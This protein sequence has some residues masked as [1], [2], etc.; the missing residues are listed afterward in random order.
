MTFKLGSSKGLQAQGGNINSTMK[1]RKD[2]DLSVPGVP[3]YKKKLDG[4]VLGEANI[5]GSIY[6]SESVD[7]NDPMMKRVLNHEMQHVTAMKIGS[8]TYDDNA[9]YFKGEVWPRGEGY[10]TN[11]HTGQKMKEGDSRLPWESNKIQ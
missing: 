6:V 2:Q 1:F 9:V 10:I 7:P 11:P 3:V 8:E 4:D 5:D